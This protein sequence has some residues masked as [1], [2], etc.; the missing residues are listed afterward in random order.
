[1]TVKSDDVV[2]RV[3]TYE[4]IIKGE[5]IPE[6]GVPESFKVLLKEMQS[7]GLDVQ[8]LRDDGTEVEMNENIDY[9]DTELRAMLEGERRF[10]R[11]NPMRSLAI[12]SRNSRIA[13]W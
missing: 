6:P 13:S 10:R 11:R 2:G 4:A 5:N 8:V 7:L 1:M 9:G 3:K 12:R